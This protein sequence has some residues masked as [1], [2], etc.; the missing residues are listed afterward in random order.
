[1]ERGILLTVLQ[2]VRVRTRTRR[3]DD[4]HALVKNVDGQKSIWLFSCWSLG[5]LVPPPPPPFCPI[6]FFFL[7]LLFL[8][9]HTHSPWP[10]TYRTYTYVRTYVQ[11]VESPP[12]PPSLLC[13]SRHANSPLPSIPSTVRSSS[14]LP[15]TITL[16]RL[17]TVACVTRFFLSSCSSPV[18]GI[19]CSLTTVLHTILWHYSTSSSLPLCF[20]L[21]SAPQTCLLPPSAGRRLQQF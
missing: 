14:L 20:R 7:F 6:A 12:S 17:Y 9:P 18:F 13:F 16:F 1:M 10:R 2:N 4:S 5:L 3:T 11:T 8:F 15:S 19:T 21:S